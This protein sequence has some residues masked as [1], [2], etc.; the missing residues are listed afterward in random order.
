M[1]ERMVALNVSPTPTENAGH[2]IV[3][4]C[5]PLNAIHLPG[6][7]LEQRT[8]AALFR[9][10]TT[11][12]PRTTSSLTLA[13]S[14][15]PSRSATEMVYRHGDPTS[16]SIE[17]VVMVA[18]TW[19]A[20]PADAARQRVARHARARSRIAAILG[21]QRR[22]TPSG[23]RKQKQ[24]RCIPVPSTVTRAGV[25]PRPGRRRR[26]RRGRSGWPFRPRPRRRA[27]R[28][29]GRRTSREP[30]RSAQRSPRP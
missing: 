11:T 16:G 7:V 6:L 19:S 5:L 25:Q 24:R 23:A 28:M 9:Q 14:G 12:S 18:R 4:A 1:P 21:G 30:S 26:L 29:R 27:A 2:T 8:M 10:P 15:E 22:Q 13:A 17:L 20:A 3:A